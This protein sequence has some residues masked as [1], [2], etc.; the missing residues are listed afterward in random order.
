[1]Y[2][3]NAYGAIATYSCNTGFGL[4]GGVETQTCGE[5]V[6]GPNGVWE[7]VVPTC[8]GTELLFFAII[9]ILHVQP[10]LVLL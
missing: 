4:S 3:S 9:I 6:S 10:S 1:M 7:G 2:G 5:D 8:E